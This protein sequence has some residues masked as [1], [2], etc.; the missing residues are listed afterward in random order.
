MR[1]RSDTVQ[2]M[3]RPQRRATEEQRRQLAAAVR[4]AKAADQMEE[5]AWS[6][7]K[8]GRDLGIPDTVL[9]SETGRSRATLNRKFGRRAEPPQGE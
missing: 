2:G 5:E 8:K 7:I 6:E 4:A 1:Q 3:I 9:C